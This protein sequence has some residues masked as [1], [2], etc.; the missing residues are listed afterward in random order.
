MFE[1]EVIRDTAHWLVF[2]GKDLAPLEAPDR[3]H[4]HTVG[5]DGTPR[6][7]GEFLH[8]LTRDDLSAPAGDEESRN[9]TDRAMRRLRSSAIREYEVI[10]RLLVVGESTREV[11]QWLCDRAI[12]N[13]IPLPP[14][15]ASH[16]TEKDT[17]A[18]V[19]GGIAYLNSVY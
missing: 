6:W 15:R 1:P 3:I 2:Y 18:L 13:N 5:R 4:S 10:Y 14:G 7:A 12:R 11:T 16:Y 19:I 8:W 17:L 9:R